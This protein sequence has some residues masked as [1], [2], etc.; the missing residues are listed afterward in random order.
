[1]LVLQ[2]RPGLQDSTEKIHIRTGYVFVGLI[3]GDQLA[4]LRSEIEVQARLPPPSKLRKPVPQRR[5]AGS[6]G[7]QQQDGCMLRCSCFRNMLH[8]A[9]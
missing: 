1:M 3:A 5:L 9:S 2:Q 4:E 8:I 7:S 6:R